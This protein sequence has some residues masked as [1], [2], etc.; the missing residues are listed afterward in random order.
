MRAST[1]NDID[2]YPAASLLSIDRFAKPSTAQQNNKEQ[3]VTQ[4]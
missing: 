1:N 4:P 3:N 2:S